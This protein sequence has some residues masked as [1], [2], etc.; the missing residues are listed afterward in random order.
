MGTKTY[1]CECLKV[2]TRQVAAAIRCGKVCS[3]GEIAS[4]TGAGSGCNACHPVLRE[5]LERER[6]RRTNAA[7]NPALNAG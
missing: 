4:C 2:T 7:V 1:V 3:V 5:M 6:A